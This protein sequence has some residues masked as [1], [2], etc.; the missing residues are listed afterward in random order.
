MNVKEEELPSYPQHTMMAASQQTIAR[1]FGGCDVLFCTDTY[2]FSD[3]S[4]YVST[5]WDADAKAKRRREVFPEDCARA[6][7]LGAKLATRP[8]TQ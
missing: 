4:K 6:Y 7:E 8:R 5:V 3:Y 1:F 2:Q